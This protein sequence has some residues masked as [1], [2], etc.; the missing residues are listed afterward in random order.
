MGINKLFHF[1]FFLISPII[2]INAFP[3]ETESP[4]KQVNGTNTVFIVLDELGA[5]AIGPITDEL[6]RQKLNVT[7]SSMI[8]A[9]ENTINAIP[10][11]LT[12][13]NYDQARPCSTTTICSNNNRFDFT[14]VTKQPADFN[15]VGVHHPYCAMQGLRY[16]YQAML[17]TVSNVFIDM[18]CYFVRIVYRDQI[19]FCNNRLMPT[20]AV[21]KVRNEMESAYYNAPFWK[22]GGFLFAHL[23]LPHPPGKNDGGSLNDD[24]DNNIMDATQLISKTITILDN[25]FKNNY[26]IV[27]TSDHPLR[28]GVWCKFS[29]YNDKP[30]VVQDKFISKTVPL[31]VAS[32]QAVG[33]CSINDNKDIFKCLNS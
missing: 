12:G 14:N 22:E 1:I 7:V 3:Q 17:P 26:T 30:C 13:E 24:Y 25:N 11:M 32:H 9:G 29:R 8:P 28:L 23:L 21:N 20:A 4:F 2:I 6:K 19:A 16:C 31:I 15:V 10:A 27:V 18:G 33:K 5:K